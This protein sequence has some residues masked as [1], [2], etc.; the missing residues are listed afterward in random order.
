MEGKRLL[1]ITP[2]F[3]GN[4]GGAAV[5]YRLLFQLLSE[6]KQISVSVISEA[7]R[8]S[9]LDRYYGLFPPW[10]GKDRKYLR[11]LFY[12]G[13]QNVRYLCV[14]DVIEKEK[15]DAVLVH[16]SF[17]NHPGIFNLVIAGARKKYKDIKFIVDVRDRLLPTRKI[18]IMKSFDNIIACSENVKAHLLNGGLREESVVVVPVIQEPIEINRAV[19]EK[20]RN[21]YFGDV[22]RF[23]IYVGAVKEDKGVDTLLRAYKNVVKSRFPDAVLGIVGLNKFRLRSSRDLLMSEGV[24]FLGKLPREQSLALIS[25]ASVCVNVS[26]NEG[27]PR[28]SLEA[29]ALQRPVLLPPNVPEFE[30]NCPGHVLSEYSEGSIGEKLCELLEN[31]TVPEYPIKSHL[32]YN[33]IPMY[34]ALLRL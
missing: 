18:P 11:D 9:T 19:A 33:V 22:V 1:I 4:A 21:R 3:Y 15:P 6:E 13:I 23:I 31:P 30:R 34:K 8:E 14:N 25:E 27:M 24:R 10:A 16:S 26:P 7:E 28:S 20:I 2:I 32:A 29:L 17:F 5:Y 12:Y